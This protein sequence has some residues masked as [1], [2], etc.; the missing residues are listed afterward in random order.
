M[1]HSFGNWVKRRR[2]ALDLTQQEL[3]GR[4]GCSLATIVKIE[5]DERRPSRQIAGLLAQHL[6]IPPDQHDLFL[7]IAR[8]E[9]AVDALETFASPV[10]NPAQQEPTPKAGHLPGNLPVSS[11]TLIGRKHET[12]MVGRQLLDP[13]CRMLTLTGPG[14]VGKTRLAIEAGHQLE[15]YFPDG[16]F[17]VSMAG[18]GLTE[19]I[20]PTIAESIGLTFSGPAGHLL[21]VTTFLRT[22]QIL[23]VVDNM[24][25]LIEGGALLGELLQQTQQVKMLT[26]SRQPLRLQ[27]EWLFE[28]HGLP[29]PEEAGGNL[30]SNSASLLFIQRARQTSRNFS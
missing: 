19:S 29:V 11:T 23:L 28:V 3:A 4:I 13:A 21:Q 27:W 14:G 15:S 1:D 22:K 9:K 10:F 2:K 8:Q 20:L 26:T 6:E 24:E 5:S 17:F 18:V 25:H 16:V 7:K 30:E 12:A